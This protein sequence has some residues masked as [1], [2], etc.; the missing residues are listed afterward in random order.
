MP[1][2]E[3]LVDI[4][5]TGESV[6][7]LC[8]QDFVE[9]LKEEHVI[10]DYELLVNSVVEDIEKYSSLEFTLNDFDLQYEMDQ[11]L[12]KVIRDIPAPV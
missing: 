5:R 1:W 4:N 2:S 12:L 9:Q 3:I 8:L 10:I 6:L 11:L 7:E